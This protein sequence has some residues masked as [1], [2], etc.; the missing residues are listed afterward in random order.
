MGNPLYNRKRFVEDLLARWSRI[1]RAVNYS[2][3]SGIKY[4]NHYNKLQ[5][6]KYPE[7]PMY[8]HIAHTEIL[9][10]IPR[11]PAI[12]SLSYTHRTRSD[13]RD[14]PRVLCLTGHA[15]SV[16][17]SG[18]IVVSTPVNTIYRQFF[19]ILNEEFSRCLARGTAG[20]SCDHL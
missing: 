2:S 4:S 11:L 8:S 14:A 19:S 5:L 6:T 15:L 13:T 7:E 3:E 18:T 12:H 16:Y 17:N 20:R 9:S 10:S 1:G